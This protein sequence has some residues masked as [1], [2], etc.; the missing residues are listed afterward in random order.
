LTIG[1]DPEEDARRF[2]VTD[3]GIVVIAKGTK[4]DE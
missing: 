3:E 4:L 1:Y 2:T